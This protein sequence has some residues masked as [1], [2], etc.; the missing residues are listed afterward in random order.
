MHFELI[1]ANKRRS[2]ALAVIFV[3]LLVGVGLAIN[4]LIGYGIVGAVIALVIAAVAAFASY[5]KSDVVALRI[6]RAVPADPQQ[7]ARL[8][9]LVEGLCIASGLP[10]PRVYVIDDPAP[11][12]FATGRNPQHAAI[13]VTT[14]LLEMMNRVE[15]EGVVAHELSHIRNYDI[16]VSTLAVTM[17]GALAIMSD[18]AIRVMWWNGGRTRRGNDHNDN[19]IGALVAVAGFLLLMFA[20]LIAQLLQFAVSRKRESLADLSAIEMTRY[21]PGLISALEKLQAD[22]TVTH[23]ASRATAHLWIE[24]PVPRMREEGRLANLNRLFDTHPP[25]EDRIAALREL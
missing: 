5:W 13:A 9:N 17:V 21:P 7:Y 25:L 23:S 12:A 8:H 3:L 11:N 20:P 18:L 6:S 16:L 24:Q 14:G 19:P 10:K 22:T 15:L 2:L 1:S 4:A